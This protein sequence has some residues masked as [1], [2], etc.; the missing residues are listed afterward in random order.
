MKNFKQLKTV[1]AYILLL[2]M[3]TRST[4]ANVK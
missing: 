3:S 4:T 1:S 2:K